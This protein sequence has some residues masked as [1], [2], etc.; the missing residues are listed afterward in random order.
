MSPFI[1]E[2]TYEVRHCWKR[3]YGLLFPFSF[4]TK[5][6]FWVEIRTL[7]R[8]VKFVHSKLTH[9]WKLLFAQV[10]CYFS[11]CYALLLYKTTRHNNGN[12][13]TMCLRCKL[14][15]EI[16]PTIS[17]DL[18]VCTCMYNYLTVWIRGN[19]PNLFL[20]IIVNCL[21]FSHFTLKKNKINFK[22]VMSIK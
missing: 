20:E 9:L 18:C 14:L 8:P 1:L 12:T 2:I 6:F 21:L 15:S 10:C 22:Q 13:K 17:W 16:L 7:C 5:V 4:I 3:I 11:H 19:N